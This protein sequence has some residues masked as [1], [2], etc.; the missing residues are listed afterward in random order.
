MDT[1]VSFN[2]RKHTTIPEIF[3]FGF[4]VKSWSMLATGCVTILSYCY[5]P[6]LP[7][8]SCSHV[9]I[10]FHLISNSFYSMS[11]MKH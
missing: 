11:I 6:L 5:Y 10:C 4:W 7:V 9:C 2:Y 8:V 1:G 3:S